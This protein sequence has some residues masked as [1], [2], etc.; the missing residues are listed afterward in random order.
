MSTGEHGG[1]GP[2]YA[3]HAAAKHARTSC[4]ARRLLPFVRLAARTSLRHGPRPRPDHFGPSIVMQVGGHPSTTGSNTCKE[5]DMMGPL[6]THAA[7]TPSLHPPCLPHQ[8][9]SMG[10]LPRPRCDRADMQIWPSSEYIRP[11][12][13]LLDKE[14]IC[15]RFRKKRNKFLQQNSMIFP[16]FG[17]HPKV[18]FL[19]LL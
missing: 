6:D 1:R 17:S 3:A 2:R 8:C 14:H 15:A 11:C 4:A 12:Y 18:C 7:R 9:R 5:E 10:N 16:S 19:V 13:L